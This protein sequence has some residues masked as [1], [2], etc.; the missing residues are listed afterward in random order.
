MISCQDLLNLEIFKNIKLLAGENGLYK[1]VT[2]PYICQS[3]DFYKWINGGELLF[4]TGM[5]MDL[6]HNKLVN[7]IY[8]C[9]EKSISGLVIL[10][11]SEFIKDIPPPIINLCDEIDLPLFKMPWNLKI[12]D[13]SKSISNYI[14]EENFK[15]NRE[16]ELL[17]ELIFTKDLNMD[18]I[19]QLIRVYNI[20]S[21]N[22]YFSCVFKSSHMSLANYDSLIS[23]I[24]NKIELSCNTLMI[25]VLNNEIILIVGVDSEN[26][27]S[28]IK[29]NLKHIHENFNK[30]NN[31]FLIFGDRYKNLLSIKDSYNDAIKAYELYKYNRWNDNCIDY[32]TLGFYKILFEVNSINKLR[33][34]SEEILKPLIDISEISNLNLLETLKCYLTNDCNLLK[35]SDELFIHRNTL[36]YRLSKIKYVLKNNL[37]S[38]KFKNELLNALMIRDYLN[39]VDYKNNKLKYI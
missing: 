10:T 37:E 8:K 34:Y 23:K 31:L 19:H 20:K 26:L 38:A 11:N 13:V 22:I 5:G 35:T 39:Y 32:S 18:K 7:L 1:T 4:L 6:D 28:K 33:D 2:W 27:Y 29:F 9:R 30:D 16:R 3:I 14:M 36:I 21:S 17:K 15:A 24:K 25:D 12:I